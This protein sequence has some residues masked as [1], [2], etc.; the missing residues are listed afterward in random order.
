LTVAATPTFVT[1]DEIR[2]AARTLAAV[3][4]HTPLL[5]VDDLTEQL[6]VPV[7]I[8]PESLQRIGAFKLRG[9]YNLVSQLVR[10]GAQGVITYSSGNHGQAV[11]Y[12]AKLFGV[13]AV[14]VMPETVTAAK[15]GG[16]ERLG[17]EV[18]LA[19][20]TSND[21]YVKAMEIAATDHLA[22]VPPFDHPAIIAGQGT[23]GL[24][25]LED[26]P[27]LGTV[28][29]PTGGGGLSAGVATAVKA[30]RPAAE[31]ITVEPEGAPKFATSFAQRRRVQLEKTGSIADGLI[32]LSV[33]ELNY[34]HLV[35]AVSRAVTV[36]DA[37]MRETVRYAIDRLKIVL[38]PSG[39]ATLAWLRQQP[40]GSLKGPVVA[41]LSGGNIE[42]D[43]LKALL[44]DGTA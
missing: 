29:V 41:V 22:V 35:R 36:S 26:C 23:V 32:T 27:D 13:R 30:L 3:A 38:E 43:G 15:R 14:I 1:L 37:A 40:K 8:K 11:A 20:R 34:Q 42:W 6:G 25:I 5:P 7:F 12:A 28:L 39:A 31:V 4:V 9:G 44:D 18:V 33:G 19:G 10:A 16:V 17:G 21:R 24:E 2:A